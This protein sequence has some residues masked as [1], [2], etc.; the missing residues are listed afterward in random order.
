MTT[1]RTVSLIL[2]GIAVVFAL[3]AILR[4]RSDY[5]F[6]LVGVV[7]LIFTLVPGINI[8]DIPKQSQ[9]AILEECL[10]K[11]NML[12]DAGIVPNGEIS[13]EDKETI[14]SAYTYLRFNAE[15]PLPQW[16]A[17]SKEKDFY[18]VFGFHQYQE[19]QWVY[20]RYE[21]EEPVNI[22]G[23]RTME[24][25]SWYGDESSGLDGFDAEAYCLE[26]R[27]MYGTS[28]TV[29]LIQIDATTAL[30]IKYLNFEYLPEN[31][32]IGRICISGYLLKK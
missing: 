4:K 5:V 1:P 25:F 29:G 20:H 11:N 3:F 28:G 32:K 7:I 30:A 23:Y 6:G 12:T 22:E 19:D 27:Q 17:D 18:E 13:Q 31:N 10:V 2:I 8:I 26:L 14:N 16:I 24:P 9:I 15:D 21:G